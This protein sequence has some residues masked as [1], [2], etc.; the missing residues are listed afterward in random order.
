MKKS[1]VLAVFAASFAGSVF[2]ASTVSD[3]VVRQRWPWSDKVDIDY[4]LSGDKGDVT[5]SA[6]WDGQ[7]TPVVLG[8]DFQVEAGQ[9]RFE[10]SPTDNY[11]GQTLTGFTVT[12][13]PATF[14]DHKY[15][16]VDLVN[17]GYSFLSAPPEG[18]WTDE[19]KSTK[20][21]FVRCPAGVYTNGIDSADFS[22]IAASE[23]STYTSVYQKHVTTFTSD[24]YIGLFA[25][26]KAQ[27]NQLTTGTPGSA[28][29]IKSLSYGQLRGLTND[30]PSINWPISRY[31]VST[32][33][34]VAK[35]RK[36]ASDSL[37]ID[38]PTEEQFEAAIR[39]GTT[40]YWP[41][42]GTRT[43]S[44]ETLTN[45]YLSVYP[46][47]VSAVGSYPAT[48][49]AFGLCDFMGYACGSVC[50]DVVRPRQTSPKVASYPYYGLSNATDPVGGSW[51]VDS[52]YGPAFLKQ[53]VIKGASYSTF[54]AGSTFRVLLPCVRQTGYTT[55]AYCVRF[56][57]HLKPLN[58]PE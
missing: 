15:L 2:A 18:G 12:A 33:S 43:D 23:A 30:N 52:D 10:W 51:A 49:N 42:G 3:V 35:L 26:S 4:T 13:T 32:N 24:W 56:A 46:S 7:A 25:F 1:A 48:T 47:S 36:K 39:C 9:H 34:V 8:T 28:Y 6:T 27:Y 50:L 11:D 55:S 19:Y 38:L 29:D 17:G 58:F 45:L 54:A 21:V 16:I 22:Y 14:E 37:V 53:R 31:N 44:F 20:M 5:F 41:C 57:I 40:T